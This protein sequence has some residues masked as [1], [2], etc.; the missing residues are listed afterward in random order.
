[1]LINY[2]YR[3][4]PSNTITEAKMLYA[5]QICENAFHPDTNE[6]QNILGP[7]FIPIGKGILIA[8][9]LAQLS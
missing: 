1:M 5:Q 8:A 4:I 2:R 3:K 6:I 7:S 9:L